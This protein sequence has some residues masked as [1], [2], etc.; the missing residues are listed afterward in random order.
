MYGVDAEWLRIA[1]DRGFVASFLARPFM[2]SELE[3][4]MNEIKK[5]SCDFTFHGWPDP[6]GLPADPES[7]RRPAKP[8]TVRIDLEKHD[9]YLESR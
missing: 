5:T 1:I 2:R 6:D 7:P 9:D 3:N 8:Q 4:P